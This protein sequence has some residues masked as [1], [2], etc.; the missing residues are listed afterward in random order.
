[1]NRTRRGWLGLPLM[2]ALKNSVLG[3]A[4]QQP[5]NLNELPADLSVPNHPARA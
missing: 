2:L 4:M 5:P 1:M 3:A